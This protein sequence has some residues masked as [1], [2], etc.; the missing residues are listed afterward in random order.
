MICRIWHGWASEES[1]AAYKDFLLHELF[2]EVERELSGRGF[3]GYGLLPTKCENEAKFAT[4]LWFESLDAVRVFAGGLYEVTIIHEK[5]K[6]LLPGYDERC[7]HLAV[8]ESHRIAAQAEPQSS[9][10]LR[11]T[12][13][14]Y[15]QR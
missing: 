5:A 12:G 15:N 3:R 13:T 7:Q 10:L 11:I 9:S 2:P 14:F 4:L 1:A 8:V 6:K